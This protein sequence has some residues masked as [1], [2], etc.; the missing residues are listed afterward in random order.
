M[1]E[2]GGKTTPSQSN[3][4]L[5]TG[6]TGYIG[7]HLVKRLIAE[8]QG[9]R[10]LVRDI[11]S[12][13]GDGPNAVV[14]AAS[15][16]NVGQLVDAMEGVDVVY[17]LAG[18]GSP[19]SGADEYRTIF[20]TNV[21]G[22]MNVL[23]AAV[24]AGVRRVVL[25]SSASVYGRVSSTA[26]REDM[27]LKPVSPYAISKVTAELLC[28]MFHREQGLETVALRYFNV[29]GPGQ[30][31]EGP[32]TKLIPTLVQSL[33]NGRPITVYGDGSQKRDFVYIDD[34]VTGTLLAG[35]AEEIYHRKINIG[36]GQGVTIQDVITQLAEHMMVAPHIATMPSRP[37]DVEVS[38]SDV[39][40]AKQLLKYRPSSHLSYGLA[41]VAR[42][43]FTAVH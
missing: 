42:N 16:A 12:N 2:H 41:Q 27:E 17:H 31:E 19:A 1:N 24:T 15:L 32:S 11:E 3:V 40:L 8:G 37:N 36:S 22:T 25:A 5:V 7:S 20:E 28:E 6:G 18:A 9:V 21:T 38:V 23:T 4:A 43:A 29:Y 10:V 35:R 30:E 34:V 14:V 13:A 39:S 26:L 33:R